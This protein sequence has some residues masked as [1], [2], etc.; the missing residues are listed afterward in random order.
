[1]YKIIFDINYCWISDSENK[2]YS[3]PQKQRNGIWEHK[4]I[5]NLP[6]VMGTMYEFEFETFKSCWEFFVNNIIQNKNSFPMQLEDYIFDEHDIKDVELKEADFGYYGDSRKYI[7]SEKSEL[8]NYWEGEKPVVKIFQIGHYWNREMIMVLDN[9]E[10]WNFVVKNDATI[11]KLMNCNKCAKCFT[12]NVY[13]VINR[14][15]D[16]PDNNEIN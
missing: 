2:N 7:K 4:P 1:M 6:K 16:C 10:E 15:F 8:Y 11:V 13:D 9:I 5:E 3:V 14:S 12:E